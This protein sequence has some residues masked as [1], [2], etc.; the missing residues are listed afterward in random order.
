MRNALTT[1]AIAAIAILAGGT[2]AH[3]ENEGPVNELTVVAHADCSLF[4]VSVSGIALGDDV[5]A[6]IGDDEF[7]VTET[8]TTA[9]A[10]IPLDNRPSF[11]ATIEIND[12]Q[13]FDQ[14]HDCVA[15]ENTI[16][17]NVTVFDIGTALPPTIPTP[18]VEVQLE[19]LDENV[20]EVEEVAP[21]HVDNRPAENAALMLW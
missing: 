1:A 6:L 18:V 15:D 11:L 12:V 17:D 20:A 14:F 2:T 21:S 3:A 13:V 9:S 8:G 10:E 7:D 5:V 16:P 19:Q 4:Y